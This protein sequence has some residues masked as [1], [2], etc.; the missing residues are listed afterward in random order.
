MSDLVGIPFRWRG[1]DRTGVDCWGLLVLWYHEHGVKIEDPWTHTEEP[2]EGA[3]RAFADSLGSSSWEPVVGPPQPGDVLAYDLHGRGM[4]DHCGVFLPGRR[5][6]HACRSV[7]VVSV[8]E[9][10]LAPH[11][12]G[13]YRRRCE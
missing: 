13:A 2:G 3:L 6:L 10:V 12:I 5:V 7:G 1:R 9:R 11:C 8:P 4:A